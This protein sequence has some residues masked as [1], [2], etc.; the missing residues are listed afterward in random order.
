MQLKQILKKLTRIHYLPYEAFLIVFILFSVISIFALRHNNEQMIKLRDAVYVADKNDGNV[1][2]ALNNLRNYVYGHMNTDLSGGGN[3]IKPP[4]QLKY[5]YER[6]ESK[7]QKDANN[8]GLYTAAEDYCQAKIPA[9]VSFSGSGRISC[10][11]G[12]IMN[13]GGRAAAE[14]PTALYEFDFVSPSWSPDL[15]GWSVVIALLSL[16]GFAASLLTHRL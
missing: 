10:V 15:A 6:L 5:T 16:I 14:I 7:A 1:N 13:H 12:Y 9:S 4:I 3:N 8:T 11:Q 2:K